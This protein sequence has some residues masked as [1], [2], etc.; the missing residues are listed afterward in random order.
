MKKRIL[1]VDDDPNILMGLQRGLYSMREEWDMN[2]VNS[3]D[4]ALAILEQETVEVVV[5]DMRMPAMTGLDLLNTVQ[6]RFPQTVRILLSGDSDRQSILTSMARAHQYLSKPFDVQQ[7]RALLMQT[8]AQ[9]DLLH[10]TTIRAYISRL[11]SIPSLPALYLELTEA[12]RSGDVSPA[13]VG[14]II[15]RDIGMTAKILQLANSAVYGIRVEVTQP[16][17]AVLLL[18]LD[19]VQSLVLSL[20]VFSSL[21]PG[22][23][24]GC[25]TEKLWEHS[26]LT[27]ALARAIARAEGVGLPQSGIYLSAGILHDIGKLVIASCDPELHR[28]IAVE[29]RCNGRSQWEMERESIGCTHAEIGAFLLGIWGLPSPIVEAVAWHHQPSRS[30]VKAFCPLAAV[31]VANALLTPVEVPQPGTFPDV[32]HEF[33]QRIGAA[34]RLEAWTTLGNELLQHRH[35][36]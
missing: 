8:I 27:G 13:R 14:E 22:V 10:N 34:D 1:F 24:S 6:D 5:S 7:L 33:L 4:A 16:E 17:Q 35:A 28:R 21:S 32:D 20:S 23:P 36:L 19:A 2:F 26:N 29:S 31:H 18:G 9:G 15:S 3:G 30:P 11:T 12:L 25:S